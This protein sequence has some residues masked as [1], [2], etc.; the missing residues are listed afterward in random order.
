MEP[1]CPL[2]AV[3]LQIVVLADLRIEL[4]MVWHNGRRFGNGN[5]F[6]SR[7]PENEM[8]PTGELVKVTVIEL[9]RNPSEAAT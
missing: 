9:D 3:V 6:F 1:A 4:V 2:I 5:G 7:D 8:L